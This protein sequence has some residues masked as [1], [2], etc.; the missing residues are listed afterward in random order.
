MHDLNMCVSLC[1]CVYPL[2]LQLSSPL[3]ALSSVAPQVD[4]W[5]CLA[6]GAGHQHPRWQHL[7]T[8]WGGWKTN[9]SW[10]WSTFRVVTCQIREKCGLSQAR[11]KMFETQNFQDLI[12]WS[13]QSGRTNDP[14]ASNTLPWKS[15]VAWPCNKG[16]APS[17]SHA[18]AVEISLDVHGI[19]KFTVYMMVEGHIMSCPCSHVHSV[20]LKKKSAWLIKVN[21]G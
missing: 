9:R 15:W 2:I 4:G 16:W 11:L 7:W 19:S 12:F 17:W 6:E 21:Q 1:V 5:R 3:A 10:E 8:N 18:R 13:V 14:Y 20:K